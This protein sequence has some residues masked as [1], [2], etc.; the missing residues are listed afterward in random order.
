MRYMTTKEIED[1][2][3][4]LLE[5]AQALR[6]PVP[7][8]LVAHRLGLTVEPAPL[9]EGVSGVLVISDGSA[10]IGVNQSH[11]AVRQ[12]F[13]VAH[14]I[15]HYLLHRKSGDLF[16]DKA[17]TAVFRDTKSSAGEDRIEVQAN[18]FAA[19]LLMPQ[20]LVLREIRHCKF[21]LG[22]EDALE[23]LAATFNVSQQAMSYRLSNLGVFPSI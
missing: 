5:R 10:T 3:A 22:D 17:Y 16:I 6:L 20:D 2:A 1:Q 13:T 9:G 11:P 21:D 23:Q 12:R 15:G 8:E 18:L 7:V 4:Q 19:A 14:E